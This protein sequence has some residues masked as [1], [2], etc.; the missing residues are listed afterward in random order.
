MLSGVGPAQHLKE[1]GIPVVHDL[2]G[3]GSHLID[4]PVVDLYFKD[5]AGVSPKYI[6]P[7]GIFDFVKLLSAAAEYF[8]SHKGHLATNVRAVVNIYS[9]YLADQRS[10]LVGGVSGV[11]SVGRS[12]P[13]PSQQVYRQD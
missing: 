6:R 4:H 10:C 8:I 13:F 1:H 9:I 2:P 11:L 12:R 3:V 7:T 5:K